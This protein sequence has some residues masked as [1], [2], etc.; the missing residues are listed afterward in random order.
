MHAVL[1]APRA[2]PGRRPRRA[3][4]AAAGPRV[5]AEEEH[6]DQEHGQAGGDPQPA[7][8]V[9][10]ALALHENDL[11]AERPRDLRRTGE[12]TFD[13]TKPIPVDVQPAALPGGDG[14]PRGVVG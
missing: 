4:E 9:L 6:V 12:G 13:T 10:L 2:A 14:D 11:V 5:R 1:F 8:D 3:A 7:G